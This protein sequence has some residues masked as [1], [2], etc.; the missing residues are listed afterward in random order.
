MTEVANQSECLKLKRTHN[1]MYD[2][3]NGLTYIYNFGELNRLCRR[4]N[5]TKI[6][7]TDTNYETFDWLRPL[8]YQ[9]QHQQH[10]PG[11]IHPCHHPHPDNQPLR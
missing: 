4:H 11:H 9:Y 3:A 7:L 10:R 5:V 8:S 6:Y 2:Y 1:L